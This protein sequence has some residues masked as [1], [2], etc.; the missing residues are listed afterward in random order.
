MTMIRPGLGAMVA[1][2]LVIL[3]PALARAE[4]DRMR[5][6]APLSEWQPRAA[7]VTAMAAQGWTVLSIRPDDGC[8]KLKVLDADGRKS[9]IVLDPRTLEPVGDSREEGDN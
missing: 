2:G 3:S 6:D 7:V 5:C 1:V 8:Y 4:G 9:R